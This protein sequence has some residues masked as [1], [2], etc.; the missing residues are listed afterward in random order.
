MTSGVPSSSPRS[1]RGRRAGLTALLSGAL[2]ASGIVV[3]TTA[4]GPATAAVTNTPNDYITLETGSINEL[5]LFKRGVDGPVGDPQTLS[6]VGQC[7]LDSDDSLVAI[8]AT[9]VPGLRQGSIGAY[10]KNGEACGQVNASAREE[11]TLDLGTK[12]ASTAVLDLELQQDAVVLATIRDSVNDATP[13][14]LELQSGRS[15]SKRDPKVPAGPQPTAVV[16]ACQV[17]SSSGPNSS[18]AD[19]CRWVITQ[20][21]MKSITL[22]AVKGN[23]SLEGGADGTA[24]STAGVEPAG[25]YP[26]RV[27][28]FVLNGQLPACSSSPVSVT[29]TT[30][31]PTVTVRNVGVSAGTCVGF[32]FSL[33][34]GLVANRATATFLKPW[35]QQSQVLQ[36]MMDLEWDISATDNAE[37]KPLEFGFH[38]I[39]LNPGPARP[40]LWCSNPVFN[41]NL[42]TGLSATP[43]TDFETNETLFP[44]VQYACMAESKLV[45]ETGTGKPLKWFQSIYVHGDAYARR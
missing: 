18:S 8:D 26:G 13:V 31:L 40:L 39:N 5:N 16:S 2:I 24:A 25:G 32:S 12:S 15:I 9:N 14:Y 29:G 38:D 1:H 35:S 27:S 28:Y 23:F 22:T 21:F 30:T 36:F 7:E 17:R 45:R 3:A 6:I 42:A 41:G 10:D 44:G 11:L 37:L 33:T 20:P 43:T 19:N 4:A 34:S